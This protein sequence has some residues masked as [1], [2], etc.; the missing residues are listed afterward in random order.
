MGPCIVKVFLSTTNKMQR[1][2]IF[3]IVN[4]VHVLSG[5]FC[6]SSGAQK[7]YMQHRVLVKLVWCDR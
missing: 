4:A 2:T 3:F 7:V 5:F 6:L 1:Y